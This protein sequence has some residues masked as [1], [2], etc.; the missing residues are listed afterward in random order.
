MT[1]LKTWQKPGTLKK[2]KPNLKNKHKH[3]DNQKM[4]NMLNKNDN[5]WE[6][7]DH[8]IS[9]KKLKPVFSESYFFSKL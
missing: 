9:N 5:W 7:V 1:E 8:A 4:Y 3:V 2:K 6:K